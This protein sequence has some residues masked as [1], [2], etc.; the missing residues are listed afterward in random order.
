MVLNPDNFTEQARDALRLSQEMTRRYRHSQWDAEHI[1]MALLERDGGTTAEIL[2]E[3]GAPS[4]AMRSRLH[5][6]LTL[7]PTLAG[8]ANQIFMTPRAEAALAR[9]KAEAD[10]LG[11]DFISAEH[12]LIALT[13]EERGATADVLRAFGVD[14][15]KVYAALR[16]VRGGHRVTDPRAESRYK[17]LERFSVDLTALA[18][19]GELDPVIGRD[20]EIARVMQTLMRR[21]KNNPALI[22]GAGV[23]KTAVAEGVASASPTATRQTRSPASAF[24]RS[25]WAR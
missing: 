18:T 11:D 9:A 13:R 20:G 19:A 17:S 5:N 14:A 22:G 25:T 4:A 16:K 3:I 7:M 2:A 1:L 6:G 8:G 23:G 12:L 10:R 15:E 24:S 21:T